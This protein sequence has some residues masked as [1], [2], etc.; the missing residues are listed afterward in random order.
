MEEERKYKT[1]VLYLRRSKAGKHL[2]MFNRE[3]QDGKSI[4]GEGVSSLLV[5]VED[6]QAVL[7]GSEW[8]K[9]S[10][11]R[12]NLATEEEEVNKEK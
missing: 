8:A 10:V 7:G 1:D 2:Y 3:G 6:I 11:M 12:E 9:V 5:N 4:L